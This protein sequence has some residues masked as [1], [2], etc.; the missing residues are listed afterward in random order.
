MIVV[1]PLFSVPFSLIVPT[2]SSINPKIFLA[3]PA[4]A[5]HVLAQ[6]P[7]HRRKSRVPCVLGGAD[8][9]KA[10][11]PARVDPGPSWP[12]WRGC[13]PASWP[14]CL[15]GRSQFLALPAVRQNRKP[16]RTFEFQGVSGLG[17]STTGASLSSKN[18]VGLPPLG[19]GGA[20]T[21]WPKDGTNPR[22]YRSASSLSGNRLGIPLCRS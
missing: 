21:Q 12:V 20:S 4:C 16:L 22:R 8:V 10:S 1:K 2:L 13:G 19:P 15:A 3:C 11:W 7:A 9:V 18:R 17:D 5:F 14:A 6:N